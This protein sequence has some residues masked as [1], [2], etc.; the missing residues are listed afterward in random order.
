MWKELGLDFLVQHKLKFIIYGLIIVFVFPLEA[1]FL[2]EVY[3]NL[4]EK[5][6]Q[7]LLF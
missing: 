5:L 2:P 7:S 6:N 3:G 4:F 1:I